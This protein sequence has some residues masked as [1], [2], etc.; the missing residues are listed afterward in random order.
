MERGMESEAFYGLS[1]RGWDGSEVSLG[2]FRGC[3]IMI[4]NV[5]SSCKFA[6]SNY[7]SFAGLLDK[8]YRK[9]LRILLFPCNQYLGQESRP[10][11]EI[12]EEVS[13]KYSDRFVVFDKVDV[14][15]KGAHPVFRHLVNTKNGKGRLG[16]F[17]KWNF[18][19]FLVD[20]KGC[21]VKRFGP[22]DIVK[23]DDENL[24]RSI[25]DGENGMQNS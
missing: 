23:E 4:A 16:N 1:A 13:K 9:G 10:I 7:K 3:V 25:E 18:T 5:A 22:S 6:E 11:E 15:G 19:K 14:F 21:V 2:S 8:F 24:L 20:R 12:R 17:I